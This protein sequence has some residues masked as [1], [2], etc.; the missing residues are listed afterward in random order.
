LQTAESHAIT[1]R[2]CVLADASTETPQCL[3]D[4]HTYED[5]KSW[6]ESCNENTTEDREAVQLWLRDITTKRDS[7]MVKIEPPYI[8]P[9]SPRGGLVRA[10]M[11]AYDQKMVI[12]YQWHWPYCLWLKT[13]AGHLAELNRGVVQLNALKVCYVSLTEEL[14]QAE[15]AL[16]KTELQIMQLLNTLT[17][18]EPGDE[19]AKHRAIAQKY[20][21]KTTR[22]LVVRRTEWNR[23][24][25][26]LDREQLWKQVLTRKDLAP[27]MNYNDIRFISRKEL[28]LYM[29]LL[30]S[31]Y[32]E[33][34]ES[35]INNE[36][37]ALQ[38]WSVIKMIDSPMRSPKVRRTDQSSA[39]AENTSA[40]QPVI[41]SGNGAP[42]YVCYCRPSSGCFC[43]LTACKNKAKEQNNH[44]SN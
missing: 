13:K 9:A 20:D 27:S 43:H 15:K 21:L 12:E 24:Q 4:K 42:Q 18:T 23:A 2:V 29:P 11:E 8:D 32:N 41:D 17:S 30:T 1:D 7:V 37:E 6:L 19:S 34:R 44:E 38:F 39:P 33:E 28:E 3:A 31:L 16:E 10:L 40:E 22:E 35:E 5:L 26:C 36:T 25:C 14:E